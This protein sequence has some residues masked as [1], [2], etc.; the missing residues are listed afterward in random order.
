MVRWE[1]LYFQGLHCSSEPHTEQT[2]KT[3]GQ[4]CLS[5]QCETV[6]EGSG[7]VKEASANTGHWLGTDRDVELPCSSQLPPSVS[8]RTLI[9][10][11][12]ED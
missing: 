11:S 3:V 5:N 2:Q 4:L 10:L 6:S 9:S 1:S 8:N 12:P 7:P